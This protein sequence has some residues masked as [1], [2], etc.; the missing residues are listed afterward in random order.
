VHLQVGGQVEVAVL[1]YQ[2]ALRF[3]PLYAPAYFN[4][5]S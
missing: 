2:E 5:V 1:R 3:N 4:L